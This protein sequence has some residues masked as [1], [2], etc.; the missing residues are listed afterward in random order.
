MINPVRY[1]N[2]NMAVPESFA[3]ER[4]H[5]SLA[6][7]AMW[8]SA[9]TSVNG[10]DGLTCGV[11]IA[12]LAVHWDEQRCEQM[13]DHIIDDDT[14]EHPE[15]PVHADR[16]PEERHRLTATRSAGR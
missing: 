11:P 14:D 9:M 10:E 1:W 8:A 3:F 4:G 13:F 15:E 12:D 5:R 16:P 7:R 2:I 6:L